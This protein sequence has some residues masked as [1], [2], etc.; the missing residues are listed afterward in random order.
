MSGW[1]DTCRKISIMLSDGMDRELTSWERLR[2]RIHLFICE[3]CSRFAR[4]LRFLREAS[5]ALVDR[6]P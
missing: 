5:A 1:K 4:Q 2:I 3:A 6:T